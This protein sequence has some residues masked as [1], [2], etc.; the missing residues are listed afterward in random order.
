MRKFSLLRRRLKQAGVIACGLVLLVMAV[1]S[2]WF[3]DYAKAQ[4]PAHAAAIIASRVVLMVGA[5]AVA[6]VLLRDRHASD[7]TPYCP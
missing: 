6:L 4:P 2:L 7:R 5:V 3:L 1:T